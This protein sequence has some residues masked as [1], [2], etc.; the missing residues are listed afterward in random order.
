M[1]SASE[2]NPRKRQFL[3]DNYDI[4]QFLGVHCVHGKCTPLCWVDICW[5]PR[6]TASVLKQDN[7]PLVDQAVGLCWVLGWPE[8]HVIRMLT[9]HYGLYFWKEFRPGD[10][11]L[12]R[13]SLHSIFNTW[14]SWTL[15]RPKRQATLCMR[16]SYEDNPTKSCS[17]NLVVTCCDHVNRQAFTILI[18]SAVSLAWL[19]LTVYCTV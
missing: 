19:P 3:K 16:T 2:I 7:K 12:C 14:G 17:V 9:S 15:I 6:L 10:F 5:L 8:S 4:S 18:A 13:L 11:I 1:R